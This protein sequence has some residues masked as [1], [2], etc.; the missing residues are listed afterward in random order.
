MKERIRKKSKVITGLVAE[1][2]KISGAVYPTLLINPVLTVSIS[3]NDYGEIGLLYARTLPV[4]SNGVISV[5]VQISAP[6]ALYGSKYTLRLVLAHEF[7][8]YI[9]LVRQF[10]SFEISSQMPSSSVYEE[11]FLDA[12]RAFDP[13]KVFPGKRKLAS[14]LRNR[15]GAGFSDEKLNEKCRKLWIERGLP[16][17]KIS[18]GSNRV[19]VSVEA[20]ARSS[21]D[22]KAIDLGSRLAS[23]R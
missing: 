19:G 6:L 7:L 18:M 2:E 3:A 14:D 9:E 17:A 4:E 15:F 12:E 22:R 1:I 5:V 13:L 11:K 16:T 8:H 23:D 21:F 10:S 20:L